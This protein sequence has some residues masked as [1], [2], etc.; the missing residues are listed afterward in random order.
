M[1]RHARVI[2]PDV[3]HHVTQ[4]GNHRE[5]VFF[6][7][8]DAQAYRCLLHAYLRRQEVEVS[9]YCLMPN[10]VHLVVIPSSTDGLHRALRAIHSQYAQR[11]NRI[12]SLKG[13]LWQGRYFSS[14]LDPAY[15]L[16][17]VRYVELNPVRA[18][19]VAR[20]QDYPW[21]SA[22]AHCD[23]RYDPLLARP[24]RRSSVLSSIEDWSRWLA[25]GVAPEAIVS[26]REH[27]R[28][29]LP[30]GSNSFVDRL[31]KSAG[32]ELRLRPCGRQNPSRM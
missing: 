26:L 12:R 25:S 16:N 3:P 4:R 20:A 1:P 7:D 17:A 11:V 5:R 31:E 30:C 14:P 22:R 18:G 28:R 27:G 13:H 8:G 15:Y 9:A 2:F 19:M 29:N 32:R 10:H 23:D 21:S 6:S 24:T